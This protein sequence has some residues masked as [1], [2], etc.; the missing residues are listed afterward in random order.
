[1]DPRLITRANDAFTT[2]KWKSANTLY[3]ILLKDSVN[4]S[5]QMPRAIFA[6]IMA[7]DSISLKRVDNLV[8]LNKNRLDT[9]LRDVSKLSI[10]TKHFDVFE[11][12]LERMKMNDPTKSDTLTFA[13]LEYRLF[14]RQPDEVLRIVEKC[15]ERDPYR[16]EWQHR[17]ARAYQ[18]KGEPE[19]ALLVY[20]GILKYHPGDYESV[21][22]IGNYYYMEGRERLRKLKSDFDTITAPTPEQIAD[23]KY[24]KSFI[25][26][27]YFADARD[28]LKIADKLQPNEKVKL[29][30]ADIDQKMETAQKGKSGRKGKR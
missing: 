1:M 18:M 15:E 21:V 20:K 3:D 29:T 28:M 19:T 26:D 13:I 24:E 10:S 11:D 8:E 12:L 7:D 14:L 5:S 17:K 9:L 16:L 23:F 2:E 4:Y 30:L 22:F 25:F 6:G 27:E